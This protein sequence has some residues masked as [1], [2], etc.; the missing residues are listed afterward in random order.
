MVT[1]M[2]I[3]EVAELAQA[4]AARSSR[5]LPAIVQKNGATPGIYDDALGAFAFPGKRQAQEQETQQ[6]RR[7]GLGLG[8]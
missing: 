6:R 1:V 8:W 7:G 2:A 4:V 5:H 3:T